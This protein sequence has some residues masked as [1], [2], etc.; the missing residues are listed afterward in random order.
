MTDK[1]DKKPKRK[2]ITAKRWLEIAAR[3]V[4][5]ASE[6]TRTVEKR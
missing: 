2:R 1:K 6:G 3:L 4:E 5:T